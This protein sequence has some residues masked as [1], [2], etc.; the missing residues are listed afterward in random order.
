M[1][2]T[3]LAAM[4]RRHLIFKFINGIVLRIARICTGLDGASGPMATGRKSFF[5]G[6]SPVGRDNGK[7]G[8]NRIIWRTQIVPRVL[9]ELGLINCHFSGLSRP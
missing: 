3:P 1:R 7:E 5:W 2:P 6:S 8:Y 9:Q 4:H